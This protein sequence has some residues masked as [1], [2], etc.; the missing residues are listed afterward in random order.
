MLWRGKV[1]WRG[2]GWAGKRW[3]VRGGHV[4]GEGWVGEGRGKSEGVRGG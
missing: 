4:K 2:E 1:K 3:E